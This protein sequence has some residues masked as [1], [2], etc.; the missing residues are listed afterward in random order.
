MSS[1]L[2]AFSKKQNI[3]RLFQPLG[4]VKV[5]IKLLCS[6]DFHVLLPVLSRLFASFRTARV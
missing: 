5:Y 2:S 3:E 6:L 1:C 4:G